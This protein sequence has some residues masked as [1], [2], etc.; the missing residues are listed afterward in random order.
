MGEQPAERKTP[1]LP[2]DVRDGV[3]AI[4]QWMLDN[5]AAAFQQTGHT[6][7]GRAVLVIAM[8]GDAEEVARILKHMDEAHQKEGISSGGKIH[9]GMMTISLPPKGDPGAPQN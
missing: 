9:S 3:K 7:D 4:I 1:P 5:R 8:L 2:Q 6:G